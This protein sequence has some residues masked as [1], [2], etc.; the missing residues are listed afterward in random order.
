MA[1]GQFQGLV[2]DVPG[3]FQRGLQFRQ[4]EQLRPLQQQSAQLGIEQQQQGLQLGGLQQQQAQENILGTQQTNVRQEEVAMFERN[5]NTAIELKATPDNQKANFLKQRIQQ[6]ENFG[7]DMTQSKKALELIE[8]GRFKELA[9]GTDALIRV[10]EQAGITKSSSG[11]EQF[12]LSPGQQRFGPGGQVIAE[13]APKPASFQLKPGEQRFE[14]GRIVATGAELAPPVIPQALLTGL[15]PELSSKASAAFTAAG[16]GGDGIKAFS[17][18]VDKGTE[19][20]RR[21]ASPQIIQ[22]S[23]PQASPSETV[24]LQAAMDS[25]KTTEAGLKAAGKVRE[26]QR[27]NAKGKKFQNRAIELLDNI[28]KS[29]ELEDVIGSIEGAIDFRLFSDEES[30]V[31]SDIEEAGN[32]LTAGNLSLM[33]GVLSETDIKIIANLAGGAL[34]RKRSEKRFRA[35]VTKLREKLAAEQVVTVDDVAAERGANQQAPTAPPSGR[36]GGQLMTDAQGN[37]AFVFPDGTFEEV[38]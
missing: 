13:V 10:G 8:S 12:T 11:A 30:Q 1:I 19:Q 15:S 29:N 25:A 33:S 23:F 6:G 26:E 32:I 37:R 9:T 28:L 24:Q 20:E 31:I 3:A 18:V 34:N 5:V 21:L 7:R 2:A 17:Q 22:N 14:A 27:R 35:D 4:A 38:Q 36:E 16:G